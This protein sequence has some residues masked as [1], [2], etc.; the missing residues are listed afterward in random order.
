MD[1]PS[2]WKIISAAAVLALAVCVTSA[3]TFAGQDDGDEGVI[4]ASPSSVTPL[5]SGPKATKG[6][7]KCTAAVN[8][9]GSVLSCNHCN[10]ADTQ[11][12]STGHYQVG[13]KK[14]CTNILAA[15]GWS[16]WVQPD[17]LEGGSE[18]AFCT[19]ADREG[20]ANAVFVLC[21]NASGAV[22]A[23]FFLFVAK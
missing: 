15:N 14:P 13:F 12:T 5:A 8:S 3:R 6:S 23:S 16:R 2:R 17:T 19:T 21:E 4:T 20:D 18:I 1:K 22:N 11:R 7:V 9:D 10:A